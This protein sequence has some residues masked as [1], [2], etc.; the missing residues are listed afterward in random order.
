MCNRLFNEILTVKN[1]TN[2]GMTRRECPHC[3]K[4]SLP[5]RVITIPTVIYNGT[6]FFSTD[7]RKKEDGNS[8]T[9]G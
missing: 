8:S 1:Y 6:G 2:T 9:T 5:S 4:I 7:N 3:G